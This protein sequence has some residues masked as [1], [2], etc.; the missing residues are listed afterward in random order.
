VLAW[1]PLCFV[2]LLLGGKRG[3]KRKGSKQ[4]VSAVV[5]SLPCSAGY[6]EIVLT[7][8]KLAHV[9][10]GSKEALLKNL[11]AFPDNLNW[12]PKSDTFW[13]G[14]ISRTSSMVT[15]RFLFT[16]KLLRGLASR[17]PDF[18]LDRLAPRIG[19]GIQ[20]DGEGRIL[21]TVADVKG[22]FTESTAGGLLVNDDETLLLS[23][24]KNDYIAV[25]DLAAAA[26]L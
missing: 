24:L 20:F 17:L 10:A 12:L 22:T 18:V 5:F 7:L 11:P 21:K 19:G 25:V 2:W 6:L 13:V 23:N 4:F 26:V 8:K 15:S 1:H 9:Q 3:Q 16:P 14:F